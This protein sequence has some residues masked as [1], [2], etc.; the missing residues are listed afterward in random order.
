MPTN[1][2]LPGLGETSDQTSVVPETPN[3]ELPGGLSFDD[4]LPGIPEEKKSLSDAIPD[5]V[6]GFAAGTVGGA[7][8]V[9][10]LAVRG[11]KY[12]SNKIFDSDFDTKEGWFP[13]TKELTET[14]GVKDPDAFVTKAATTAGEFLGAEVATLGTVGGVGKGLSLAAKTA[15]RAATTARVAK[16]AEKINKAGNFLNKVGRGQSVSRSLVDAGIAGSTSASLDLTDLPEGAKTA[17]FFGATIGAG[18]LVNKG[19][20]KLASSKI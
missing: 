3:E 4:S 9:G 7:A 13:T 14:F 5:P 15:G 20:G 1:R 18:A 2:V 11:G 19:I 6:K 12:L 8:S 10:N 16:V 17:I